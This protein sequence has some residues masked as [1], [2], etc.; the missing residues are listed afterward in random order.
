MQCI[1]ACGKC[2]TFNQGFYD[3]VYHK[4]RYCGGDQPEEHD[5]QC[6][7]GILNVTAHIGLN[8]VKHGFHRL[9]LA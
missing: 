6:R 1:T 4:E 5:R 2:F 8:L 3:S 9:S 7:I